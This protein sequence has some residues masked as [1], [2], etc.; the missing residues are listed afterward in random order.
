[1][2]HFFFFFFE[3]FAMNEKTIHDQFNNTT[4]FTSSSSMSQVEF[5]SSTLKEITN[6]PPKR[7][8]KDPFWDELIETGDK[9]HCKY[10]PASYSMETGLSTIKSHFRRNHPEKWNELNDA[11]T[12]NVEPYST[13]MISQ[14]NQ[15]LFK[16][17]ITDQQ[18][19]SI[20]ENKDFQL[21]IKKI[22]LRYPLPSRQFV[23]QSILK[24]HYEKQHDLRCFFNT[25]QQKFAI[26]TDV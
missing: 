24:L 3:P 13:D 7:L 21:F 11:I 18:A 9:R 17:I 19:F 6:F 15:Y 5:A 12:A 4:E 26:T 2:W 8:K 22:T 14:I 20:V 23:S 25:S 10:C 16:W 1:M